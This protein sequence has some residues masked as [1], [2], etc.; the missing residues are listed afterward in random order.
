MTSILW[1]FCKL[2]NVKHSFHLTSDMKRSS[3]TRKG[4]SRGDDVVDDV[5]GLLQTGLLYSIVNGLGTLIKTER[6]YHL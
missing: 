1:P 2:Q 3:C 5:T 4:T 6:I